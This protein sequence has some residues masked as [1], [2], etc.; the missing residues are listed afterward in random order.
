MNLDKV[1]EYTA[2]QCMHVF[3]NNQVKKI[4]YDKS[5]RSSKSAHKQRTKCRSEERLLYH[6]A[7]YDPY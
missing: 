2:M 7:F 6:P 4:A 3:L 5:D 1:A